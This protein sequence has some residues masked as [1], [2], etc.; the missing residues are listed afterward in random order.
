MKQ[1]ALMRRNSQKGF[2]LVE[3]GMAMFVLTVVALAGITY[4][5][6]ARMGEYKQWHEQS[7]LYL[8]EREVESWHGGGYIAQTGWNNTQA[9]AANFLP[10]GYAHGVADSGWTASTRQKDVTSANIKYIIKARLLGTPTGSTDFKSSDNWDPYSN[11]GFSYN[12]RQIEVHIA[13]G[14][15]TWSTASAANLLK[16]ETRLA[17]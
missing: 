6:H 10:Y 7:A 15:S 9:G 11:G 1:A 5:S 17:E 13:W 12:Y 8:A 4:Y 16:V 2:T 14:G 3:V